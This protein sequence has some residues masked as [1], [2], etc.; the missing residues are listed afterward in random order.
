MPLKLLEYPFDL[1]NYQNTFKYLK[2]RE[3]PYTSKITNISLDIQYY[4]QNL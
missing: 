2:W 3:Y 1:Q 4:P